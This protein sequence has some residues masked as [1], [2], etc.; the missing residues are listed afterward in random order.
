M[1]Y[2]WL[3]FISAAA[4]FI[5]MI[6]SLVLI[7]MGRVLVNEAGLLVERPRGNHHFRGV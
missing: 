3:L 2:K 6:G 7:A 5:V 4:G 1:D